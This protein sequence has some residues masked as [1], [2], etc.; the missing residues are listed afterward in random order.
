MFSDFEFRTSLG[1]SILLVSSVLSKFGLECIKNLKWPLKS[2]QRKFYISLDFSNTHCF[3]FL[4]NEN[5]SKY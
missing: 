2:F 3:K 5:P 4:T 1:S